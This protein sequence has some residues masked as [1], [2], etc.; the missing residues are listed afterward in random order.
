[1]DLKVGLESPHW[2]GSFGHRIQNASSYDFSP[3]NQIRP[4]SRDTC[5]VNATRNHRQCCW[6]TP[7]ITTMSKNHS[8]QR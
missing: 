6:L 8:E 1:M 2:L 4:E 3:V 5:L 7:N